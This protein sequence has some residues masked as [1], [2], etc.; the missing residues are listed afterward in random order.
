MVKLP[1]TH[2]PTTLSPSHS[3]STSPTWDPPITNPDIDAAA[4]GILLFA[5]VVLL[6]YAI[7]KTRK[8]HGLILFVG[9]IA[10]VTGAVLVIVEISTYPDLLANPLNDNVDDN[11]YIS[12]FAFFIACSIILLWDI[13]VYIYK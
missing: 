2:S 11:V 3:P 7:P 12:A 9:S 6:Y 5:T 10:Y 1:P 4:L 8:S 13:G